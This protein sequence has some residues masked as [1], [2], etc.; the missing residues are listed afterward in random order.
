LT[1]AVIKSFAPLDFRKV[2]ENVLGNPV[3]VSRVYKKLR[4]SQ[5]LCSDG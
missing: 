3:S 5:L 1:T 4:A 2:N